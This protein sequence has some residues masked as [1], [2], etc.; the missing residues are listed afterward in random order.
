MRASPFA[1]WWSTEVTAPALDA[2]AR[3]LTGS[4]AFCGIAV[5]QGSAAPAFYLSAPGRAVDPGT[6]FRVASVSKIITG[7]T[8]LAVLGAAGARLAAE[9]ILGF[10]LRHPLAPDRPVTVGGLAAHHAGLSDGAGYAIPQ[11]VALADWLAAQGDAIWSPH[12]PGARFEYCNLGYI[13]LAAVAE[14]AA[15]E[16]FDHLARRLVLDPLGIPGGFNW[17][18]V[19]GPERANRLPTYRRGPAGFVP[20]IDHEVPDR[21]IFRQPGETLAQPYMPGRDLALLSP[22]GGFRTS[23]AGLI[24]IA[25]QLPDRPARLWDRTAASDDPDRMFTGYGWGLQVLDRPAFYPRPLVGHFASAYGFLGGAW[26]DPAR[27]L[28]FAYA[29]NGRPLGEDRDDMT[30]EERRIFAAVSAL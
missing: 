20:Q 4:F 14:A 7:R 25:A 12:P 16:R 18:G 2:L 1:A 6:M 27:D 11:G 5:Q 9:D 13:L 17:S 3:S 28:S 24:R 22:Q 30:A 15:G 19:S 10:A 29:L 8:A 21:G 23:M 26:R